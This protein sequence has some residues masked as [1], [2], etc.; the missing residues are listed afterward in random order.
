MASTVT[1]FVSHAVKTARRITKEQESPTVVLFS[2][3]SASFACLPLSAWE[4]SAG[5]I[6]KPSTGAWVDRMGRTDSQR[7]FAEAAPAVHVVLLGGGEWVGS[8]DELTLGTDD[9]RTAFAPVGGQS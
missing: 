8:I 2:K 5:L 7:T 3:P 6:F 1:P 9:Q 4:A